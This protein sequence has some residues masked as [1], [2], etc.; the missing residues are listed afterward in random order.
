MEGMIKLSAP[1]GRIM[2]AFIFIMAGANKIFTYT[3]TQAYMDSMGV[4]GVLL[5]LV[6]TTELL[7]G[8]AIILGWHTRLAA[9]LL[10]GFSLLAAVFFHADFG[11]QTQMILFMKNVAMAVGFMILAHHGAGAFALDNLKGDEDPLHIELN[12]D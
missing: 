5:P 11:D 1:I 4:P 8:L 3:A 12:K 7:G 6:I 2:L 10:A 9:F